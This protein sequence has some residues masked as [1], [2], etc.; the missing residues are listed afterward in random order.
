MRFT[1]SLVLII[2]LAGTEV[3]TLSR[4]PSAGSVEAAFRRSSYTTLAAPTKVP[5]SSR[6]QTIRLMVGALSGI[7]VGYIQGT[8]VTSVQILEFTPVWTPQP[9]ETRLQ[10]CG[11]LEQELVPLMYR[12]ISVTY[13]SSSPSKSSGCHRLV[14]IQRWRDDSRWQAITP[15][16]VGI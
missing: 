6:T 9:S 16:R 12:N 13:N 10:L 4:S 8:P 14:K 7:S 5:P 15:E 2:L 1:K 3:L 11:A